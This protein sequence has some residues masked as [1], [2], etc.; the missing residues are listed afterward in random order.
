MIKFNGELTGEA[1]KH[2]YK[3]TVRLFE[4]SLCFGVLVGMV[5]MLT[6][7]FLVFRVFPLKIILIVGVVLMLFFVAISNLIRLSKKDLPQEIII[8]EEIII[9]VNKVKPQT[10]MLKDVRKVQDYGDFYYF[11]FPLT[12][13]STSFICQKS[14]LSKSTL[15]DFEKIFDGKIERIG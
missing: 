5:T 8:E 3:A 15:E 1:K 6:L 14:L 10:R 7:V 9:S 13:Y 12:Q 11:V 4:K 2:F